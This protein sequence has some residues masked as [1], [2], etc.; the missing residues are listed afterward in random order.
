MCNL[1][2]II[3]FLH[4]FF[5]FTIFNWNLNCEKDLIFD[6]SKK[7]GKTKMLH[8]QHNPSIHQSSNP[9]QESHHVHKERNSWSHNPATALKP[10]SKLSFPM[11]IADLVDHVRILIKLQSK[12]TFDYY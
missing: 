8:T 4:Y 12:L 2:L 11:K 9:S 5:R 3:K 6:E 7:H 1:K 10:S